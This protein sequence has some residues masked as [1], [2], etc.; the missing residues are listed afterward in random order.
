MIYRPGAARATPLF[1]GELTS[2]LERLASMSTPCVL[3]GD[4]NVRFDCPDEPA[5]QQLN[6]LLLAFDLH[7]HIDVPT[8]DRGGTLD[9][10][11]T[12]NDFLPDS[13]TVSEVGFSDHNMV[14]WTMNL[15]ALTTPTYIT[16]ERRSWKQFRADLQQSALVDTSVITVAADTHDCAATHSSLVALYDKT[17]TDLLD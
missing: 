5:C 7:Q 8:H 3:A 14:R 1:F 16:C 13:V 4:L 11:V 9:A 12:R 15:P 6:D 10:V 2:L 17:L